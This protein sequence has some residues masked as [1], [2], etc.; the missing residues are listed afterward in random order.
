MVGSPLKRQRKAGICADE[1]NVI[2]FLYM[3]CIADLPRGWR[4]WSPAQKIEHP[5]DM[6]LDRAHEI[7][8]CGM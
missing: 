6:S 2:A 4:H 3:P 5:L 8:S 1:G 7:L